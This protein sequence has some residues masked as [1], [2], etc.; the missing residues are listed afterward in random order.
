MGRIPAKPK[1]PVR[2]KAPRR[3]RRRVPRAIGGSSLALKSY[4]FKF[5]LPSQVLHS[6]IGSSVF[7]LSPAPSGQSP[8]LPSSGGTWQAVSASSGIA[9]YYDILITV[10]FKL[11]DLQFYSSYN[12]LFDAYKFGKV[13]CHVEYLNNVSQVTTSG[14]MPTLYTYWDQDD[15]LLPPSLL[16]LTSKQGVKIRQFGNRSKTTL[17]TSFVPVTQAVMGNVGGG[18]AT[19]GIGAKPMWINCQQPL[20]AHNALKMIITDVYNPAAGLASQA[21]RFN[22]TY[23]IAFRGPILAA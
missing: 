5:N 6:N 8:I 18:S 23:N 10:P 3:H 13:S 12:T 16:S 17:S 11:S 1:A 9:D 7:Q 20:V 2:H 15:A 14:L 22:W 21:F 19:A 4:K